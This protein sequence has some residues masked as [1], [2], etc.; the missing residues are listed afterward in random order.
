MMNSYI[1]EFHT[2]AVT[3]LSCSDQ[4]LLLSA[5]GVPHLVSAGGKSVSAATEYI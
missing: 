1:T 5:V 3:V 4:L 2:V